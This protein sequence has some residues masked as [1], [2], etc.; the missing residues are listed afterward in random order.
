M[1]MHCRRCNEVDCNGIHPIARRES[2]I[3]ELV[4]LVEAVKEHY[5][6]GSS[7]YPYIQALLTF[8]LSG[9]KGGE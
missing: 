9:L 3:A 2:S 7:C 8:D 6:T 4:K 1:A 5:K